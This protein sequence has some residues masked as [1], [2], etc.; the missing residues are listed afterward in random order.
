MGQSMPWKT[1]A[2][3]WL[4]SVNDGQGNEKEVEALRE[5]RYKQSAFPRVALPRFYPKAAVK[6]AGS[7]RRQA[8]SSLAIMDAQF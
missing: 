3:I 6:A 5:R 2:C 4:E 7:Q 1:R 8:R